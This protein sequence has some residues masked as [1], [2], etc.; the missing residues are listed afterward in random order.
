LVAVVLVPVPEVELVVFEA[1]VSDPVVGDVD[2]PAVVLVLVD[3]EEVVEL[4]D[5]EELVELVL[6]VAIGSHGSVLPE[7]EDPAAPVVVCAPGVAVWGVG[8]AV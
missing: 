4:D 5:G 1:V 8:D 7:L 2:A 6:L 3:G